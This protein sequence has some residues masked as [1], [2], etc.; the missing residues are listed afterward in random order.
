MQMVE[1]L[2]WLERLVLLVLAGLSIWSVAIMFQLRRRFME[3]S[4]TLGIEAAESWLKLSST[5]KSN[6]KTQVMSLP[7]SLA[8]SLL[9]D[10]FQLQAPRE[11]QVELLS[12]LARGTVIE[13]RIQFE[14]GL[15]VLGTLGANAPFVGLFGTVL[16]I[17]RAFAALGEGGGEQSGAVMAGISVALIATAAGLFVAIPAVVAFNFFS[18]KLRECVGRF[19]SF[20][21]RAVTA[22]VQSQNG[23]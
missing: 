23:L 1:V 2:A 3:S 11:H 18:R 4:A 14:R 7:P 22:V 10:M 21:E 12:K 8:R 13:L 16:G 15:A 6:L 9:Q 20:C 19:E 17:I 5:A